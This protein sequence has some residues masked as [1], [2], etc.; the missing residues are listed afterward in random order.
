MRQASEKGWGAASQ[1]VKAVAEER[2]WEH[3]HHRDLFEAVFTLSG[4]SGDR[5]ISRLF[6]A[7]NALH[8]NFYEG[9]MREADVQDALEHVTRFVE[10]I[11]GSATATIGRLVATRL[12]AAIEGI[13]RIGYNVVSDGH[14]PG[15]LAQ[16]VRALASHA[17]GQR[18]KSSIAHHAG[19]SDGFLTGSCRSGGTADALRSGRSAPCGRGSSNL[20]FGTTTFSWGW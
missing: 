13:G 9:R 12:A 5:D 6:W 11:R 17:R 4:E 2:G 7:A 14:A 16:L 3:N 8:T 15:R 10:K 19:P 20:P 18:F 1:I